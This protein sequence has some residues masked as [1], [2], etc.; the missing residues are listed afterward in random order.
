[1]HTSVFVLWAAQR[2]LQ[3]HTQRTPRSPRVRTSWPLRTCRACS[4]AVVS[5]VLSVPQK[6]SNITCVFLFGEVLCKSKG[7]SA[8]P[9]I[10]CNGYVDLH[11]TVELWFGGGLSAKNVRNFNSEKKTY[12]YCGK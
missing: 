4:W 2:T 10:C 8:T 7:N 11:I 6:R 3:A 1:M 12:V 9:V 5:F